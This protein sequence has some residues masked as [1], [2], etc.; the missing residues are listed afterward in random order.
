M[1][2]ADKR[3]QNIEFWHINKLF[4]NNKEDS[5]NDFHLDSVLHPLGILG[6]TLHKNTLGRWW[7]L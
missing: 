5:G 2:T 4:Q 3:R 6:S 1:P 7:S